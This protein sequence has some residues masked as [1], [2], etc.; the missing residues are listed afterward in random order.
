MTVP[1]GKLSGTAE[2]F[3]SARGAFGLEPG[4]AAV[5]EPGAGVE[6]ALLE[7]LLVS[8]DVALDGAG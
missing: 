6:A 2:G 3:A 1:A 8:G 5:A 4:A 7:G